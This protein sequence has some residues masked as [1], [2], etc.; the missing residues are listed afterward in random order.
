MTET[1]PYNPCSR[2]GEIRAKIATLLE[3]EY[4]QKNIGQIIAR[5]ADLYGHMPTRVACL[6]SLTID[7]LMN[8]KRANWMVDASKPHS[9]TYTMDCARAMKILSG[10]E[11]YFDQVWHMPTSYPAID[12]TTFINMAA[13]ELGVEPKYTVLKKWMVKM[14]GLFDK[15]VGETYEMLYQSEFNYDF[16][17]TKFNEFSII[18]QWHILRGSMILWNFLKT[19]KLQ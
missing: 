4:R 17:S 6:I 2:K 16:D 5:S 18:P 11:E 10:S 19:R 13:Q 8:G 3:D 15:T 1:T 12:G 14:F 7:K 9:F